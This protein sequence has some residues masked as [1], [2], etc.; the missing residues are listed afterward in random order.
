ME[1]NVLKVLHTLMCFYS[2]L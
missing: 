2:F 1:G